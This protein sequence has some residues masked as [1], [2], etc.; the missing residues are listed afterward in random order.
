MFQLL[1]V[2]C[3][4]KYIVVVW[5]LVCNIKYIVVHLK[6]KSISWLLGGS[7]NDLDVIFIMF[8]ILSLG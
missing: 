8:E 3:N 1:V 7:F 2:V 6:K 5:S 4:L